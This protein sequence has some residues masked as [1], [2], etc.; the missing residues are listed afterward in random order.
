MSQSVAPQ[1]G[2]LAEQVAVQQWP[3]PVVPQRPLVHWSF[4][5]HAV[6]AVTLATQVPEAPGFM[7]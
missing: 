1:A 4:A 6:P 5:E 7:Q 2:T 3:V